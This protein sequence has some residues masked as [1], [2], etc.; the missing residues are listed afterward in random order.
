MSH[1]FER[2]IARPHWKYTAWVLIIITERGALPSTAKDC[3]SCS[4]IEMAAVPFT[5]YLAEFLL[6]P[7]VHEQRVLPTPEVHWTP[8]L[9]MHQLLHLLPSFALLF[10]FL[11]PPSTVVRRRV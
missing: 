4:S 10:L 7:E 3:F 6:L 5:Q 1:N 2:N 11:H 9:A 8:K